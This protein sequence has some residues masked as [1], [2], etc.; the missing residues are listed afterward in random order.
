MRQKPVQNDN[1]KSLKKQGF[2][3]LNLDASKTVVFGDMK[4]EILWSDINT[5]IHTVTGQRTA[6]I[7]A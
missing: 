2:R 4:F 1:K 7:S 3:G 5:V 6:G